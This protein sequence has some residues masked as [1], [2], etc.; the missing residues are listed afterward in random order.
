MTIEDIKARW[1]NRGLQNLV[2]LLV[3]L[4]SDFSRN[5]II[6]FNNITKNFKLNQN[7]SGVLKLLLQFHPNICISV[8]REREED[9]RELRG[10]HAM[11]RRTLLDSFPNPPFHSAPPSWFPQSSRMF[12]SL[13]LTFFM[14]RF[15]YLGSSFDF[16]GCVQFPLVLCWV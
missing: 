10:L 2:G 7:E 14:H 9:G 6:R 1:A 13:S 15:S 4:H 11:G 8:A 3:M 12:L 5:T 16:F